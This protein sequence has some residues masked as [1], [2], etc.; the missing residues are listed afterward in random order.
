ME[1]QNLLITSYNDFSCLA[2][3]PTGNQN[4]K[5]ILFKNSIIQSEYEILECYNPAFVLKNPDYNILYIFVAALCPINEDIIIK[6]NGC[7]WIVKSAETNIGTT[8]T[9]ETI[10]WET[11]GNRWLYLVAQ[12]VIFL[13]TRYC[14][15][16]I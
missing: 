3:I 16:D 9:C 7:R 4:K 15:I 14:I 5:P 12:S 1:P 11:S 13:F 2:H 6:E 8:S 10:C